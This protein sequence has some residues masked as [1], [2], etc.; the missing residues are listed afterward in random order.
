MNAVDAPYIDKRL[1]IRLIGLSETRESPVVSFLEEVLDFPIRFPWSTV[2][3]KKGRAYFA[4][5]EERTTTWVHPYMDGISRLLEGFRS[6]SDRLPQ[7]RAEN[8]SMRIADLIESCKDSLF[9]PGDVGI[10]LFGL[11]KLQTGDFFDSRPISV[12]AGLLDEGPLAL[13]TTTLELP[14]HKAPTVSYQ[15]A[16][17]Q[18]LDLR[19]ELSKVR[20]SPLI[21]IPNP[22]IL[23]VQ[24]LRPTCISARLERPRCLSVITFSADSRISETISESP[25]C[26]GLTSFQVPSTSGRYEL[27]EDIPPVSSAVV[28][29]PVVLATLRESREWIRPR[30]IRFDRGLAKTY[31][32]KNSRV[33]PRS[34]SYMRPRTRASDN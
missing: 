15:A 19:T 13:T 29:E 33:I 21:L 14:R 23:S 27:Q 34:R 4:N 1:C 32:T 20:I 6:L 12:R 28:H 18:T 22:E 30:I 25:G 8:I 7:E 5:C 16:S 11:K 31:G 10:Q 24:Q 2:V 26:D 17:A 3:D 9:I